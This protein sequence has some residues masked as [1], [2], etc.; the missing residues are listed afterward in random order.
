MNKEN[1]NIVF[2]NDTFKFV[3]RG[4]IL[5][6]GVVIV[7]LLLSPKTEEKEVKTVVL[8]DTTVVHDTIEKTVTEIQYKKIKTVDT[9]YLPTPDT[10][11]ALPV[12]Q[13]HYSDSLS[14]IWVSGYKP[15]IDSIKYHI[16]QQTIYIDKVVEVEIEKPKKWYED[17]F[18][19]TAG[20]YGGYSPLY[21]K[22]DVI[23]GAG[24]SIRL[25]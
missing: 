5:I 21:N 11:T 2:Q 14:D 3:L 24:F 1:L 12:K 25:N 17:R 6:L 9:I 7:C 15:E 8:H 23:V 19:I 4:L 13:K 18:I 22:F 20:V 10:I 16:P